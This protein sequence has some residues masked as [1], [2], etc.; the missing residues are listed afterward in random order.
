M[1]ACKGDVADW[2]VDGIWWQQITAS[3]YYY[4]ALRLFMNDCCVFNVSI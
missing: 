2:N 4:L 3:W 1:G